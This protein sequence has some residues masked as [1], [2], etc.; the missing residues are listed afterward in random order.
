LSGLAVSL[1]EFSI[2]FNLFFKQ[3][4]SGERAVVSRVEP[5]PCAVGGRG[6]GVLVW[7][8]LC[9]VPTQPPLP[10]IVPRKLPCCWVL[11]R[12]APTEVLCDKV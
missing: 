12:S 1:G 2:S 11:L 6:G 9:A 10:G 3:K 5:W 4:A 7:G 8:Q